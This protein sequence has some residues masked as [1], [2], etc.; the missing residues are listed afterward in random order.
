MF[1]KGM[2]AMTDL[3]EELEELIEELGE[4][5]ERDFE[6]LHVKADEVLLKALK[7][8]GEHKLVELYE[9]IEKDFWYA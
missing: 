4:K 7:R 5:G 1:K 6:I 2:F 9:S 3:E 8:Y